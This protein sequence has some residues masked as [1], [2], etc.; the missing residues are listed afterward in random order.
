MV[1]RKQ[2]I[3]RM[4]AQLDDDVGYEHVIYHLSVMRSV[5]IGI[6][7]ADR[8]ETID[9]DALMAK[10]DAEDAQEKARLDAASNRGPTKH[11]A[12]H[13]TR[14]PGQGDR[15]HPKPKASARKPKKVS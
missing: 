4:I 3:L 1:N 12:S 15:I 7:Q 8:G 10:L 11:Q 13:R 2:K 5:E 9:H 14:R 6:E